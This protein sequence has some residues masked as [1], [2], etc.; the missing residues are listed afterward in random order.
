MTAVT[1]APP[2]SSSAPTDGRLRRFARWLDGNP[3]V[4]LVPWIAFSLISGPSRLEIAAIVALV[5]AVVIFVV[6][7]IRGQ[8]IKLLEL[9]DVTFFAALAIVV[10]VASPSTHRWLEL[11]SGE[12]ANIALVVIALGSIALRVPFTLQYAR[13]EVDRELWDN[14]MFVHIN[15]VL[16]WTWAAAFFV[17]AVSGWYGDAVLHNSNNLWTGWIIQTGALIV[18]A[19][20]TGWYPDWATGRAA[21]AR[22][23]EPDEPIP[24]IADLF[25]GLAAWVVTTG[26]LSLCFNAAPWGVGVG[27]IVGGGKI[28]HWART[29]KPED[30]AESDARPET[31]PA[32]A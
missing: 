17:G 10:A 31:Q 24:P 13:E 9:S 23:E 7:R 21:L 26:I 25:D 12:I 15:Y 19:E 1:G 3:L 4:G 8:S 14:P 2:E 18:A 30:P 27:F 6:G 28:Q 22:G 11:W 5:T 29:Q 32:P 16:T 20:I